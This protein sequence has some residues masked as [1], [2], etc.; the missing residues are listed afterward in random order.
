MPFSGQ[1]ESC[2]STAKRTSFLVS[3]GYVFTR[4]LQRQNIQQEAVP[5]PSCKTWRADVLHVHCVF[6]LCRIAGQEA[7]WSFLV[8]IWL[9]Q[10]LILLLFFTF[11]LSPNHS[12]PPHA[13]HSAYFRWYLSRS[14]HACVHN[15]SLCMPG[16][17]HPVYLIQLQPRVLDVLW[18]DMHTHRYT[19]ALLCTR[20][21]SCGVSGQGSWVLEW[22]KSAQR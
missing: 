4:A 1:K 8:F 16:M 11:C 14:I 17:L 12:P 10:S 20:K 9:S 3:Q 21:V 6:E 13:S 18:Q 19:H 15:M 7:V 2:K 5:A 22:A